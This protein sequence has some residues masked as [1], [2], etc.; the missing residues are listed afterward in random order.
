MD[1]VV[2]WTSSNDGPSD[3][4]PE[5]VLNGRPAGDG[6]DGT[7]AKKGPGRG[8]FRAGALADS[9]TGRTNVR[10]ATETDI[11]GPQTNSGRFSLGGE[12]RGCLLCCLEDVRGHCALFECVPQLG[13]QET[14][15]RVASDAG[16]EAVDETPDHG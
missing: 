3:S 9:L 16:V 5:P 4:S 7:H 12:L 2:R 13:P 10:F 8:Y 1:M 11:G 15:G 6:S 14:A